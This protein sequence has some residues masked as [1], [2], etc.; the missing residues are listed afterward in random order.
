MSTARLIIDKRSGPMNMA[1]DEALLLSAPCSGP[2]LRFYQWE[3]PTL[4][5]GYF[6]S[7]ADRSGHESSA[8]CPIVRRSTGG[9]AIVHDHELTYSFVTPDC[10]QDKSAA[11]PLYFA[12]HET[13]ILTLASLRIEASL[14]TAEQ[15]LQ[16]GQIEP[17]LCFQRRAVGDVILEGA[18]ICG[19]AQRRQKEAMLQHGSILL[20]KSIFAPELLGIRD[21]SAQSLTA[22]KLAEVWVP[23]LESRLHLRFRP[24]SI[25]PTE[26]LSAERLAEDRFGTDS[27]SLRR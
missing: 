21:L 7:A 5:L 8:N 24:G 4:S 11:Q 2:T 9:G 27:W 20:Q 16:V 3:V 15:L 18:K 14:F 19:S 1:V 6:Q 10:H 12:F 26:Q 17:F 22:E 25:T 23:L 13:L